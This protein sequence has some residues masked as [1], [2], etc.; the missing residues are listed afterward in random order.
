MPERAAGGPDVTESD[1][2]ISVLIP[3]FNYGRYLPEAIESVLAQD[4]RDCEI[5]ISDDASTDDS[6][7]VLQRYAACD[8]RVR[9]VL[10]PAN[11]GM[12]ANWNWCLRQARGLYVKF[13]FGDDV[14]AAPDALS[15]LVAL[16][17]ANPGARLATAARLLLDENSRVTGE[18]AHLRLGVQAG[19]A[20]IARCL[21]TRRNLI[22]EPSAV[23]FRRSDAARGF[24]PAFRQLVDLELWC[25]LLLDGDVVA[26]PAPLAG[27]RRHGR[28]QTAVNHRRHLPELEMLALVRRYVG[29]PALAADLPPG[30]GAHRRILYRHLRYVRKAAAG[31]PLAAGELARLRREL[32]PGWRGILWLGYR[33]RRPGEN[34]ARKLA[35]VAARGLAPVRPARRLA[36][37]FVAGLAGRAFRRP[38]PPAPGG[39]RGAGP[40][41]PA[42]T[43][44]IIISGTGRAGTTF[45][46]QLLTA[47][48]LD[49]GFTDDTWPLHY[50]SRCAAG[51]EFDLAD[52]HAPRIVKNPALCETLPGLLARGAVTVEHAIVP[53]RSL[54]E[55]ARSRA[56]VGG[57]GR[58]PGGLWGTTRP[59]RQAGI[60][61]EHFHRLVHTLVVHEIPCTFLD[62]PRF[63]RDP[64]YTRRQL[65]WLVGHIP[66]D[67]FAAAFARVARPELVHDFAADRSV[68]AGRPDG[69]AKL[70][71]SAAGGR[72]K[73]LAWGAVAV[74]LAGLALAVAG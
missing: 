6:A 25:H 57:R 20:V 13:L 24:D 51:L 19:P 54:E 36:N 41:P 37:D 71:P 58:T 26:T 29:A 34:L 52:R 35:G 66:A 65:H 27:F 53:V 69:G 62:F 49:T 16:L 74:V 45:L 56:G 10:Q 28:Q 12:V 38:E 59:D 48:G 43:G 9:V 3:T 47:L 70:R 61:A 64:A 33:L 7:A 32:S 15:T 55:A 50:D 5:L 39:D 14:L 60:L 11:L 31:N 67:T 18:W 23:L 8:P 21:R 1:P 44:K 46:V 22:G 40:P 73:I 30:G 72:R 68:G 42:E 4:C 63:V 2:R 17:D